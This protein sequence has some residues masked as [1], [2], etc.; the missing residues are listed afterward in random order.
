MKR[1]YVYF[2]IKIIYV[3]YIDFLD[4]CDFNLN[5]ICG[6]VGICMGI[7]KRCICKLGFYGIWCLG[8]CKLIDLVF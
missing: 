7:L 1:S 5:G 6:F 3:I 8:I 4:F 2:F